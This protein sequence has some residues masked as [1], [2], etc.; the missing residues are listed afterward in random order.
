MGPQSDPAAWSRLLGTAIGFEFHKLAD[1]PRITSGPLGDSA[2]GPTSWLR[3]K[4]F[5]G[6][7]LDEALPV[8]Q[9]LVWKGLLVAARP[10]FSASTPT[11]AEL[12]YWEL[13]RVLSAAQLS[14]S[15]AVSLSPIKLGMAE[16][17][18]G[19]R[20]AIRELVAE[21]ARARIEVVLEP[22]PDGAPIPNVQGLLDEYPQLSLTVQAS[23]A[24]AEDDC[25]RFAGHRV[26]I[27]KGLP[28]PATNGWRTRRDIDLAYL[29]CT[30]ILMAGCGY[31]TIATDDLRMIRIV[32]AVATQAGRSDSDF[33]FELRLGTHADEQRRLADVGMKARVLVPYGDD[34]SSYRRRF[35]TP[36]LWGAR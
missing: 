31:P 2:Q 29:R 16:D 11:K 19:A 8:F 20:S 4:F 27:V 12:G 24:D 33:E 25:R 5:G 1:R 15:V 7:D 36:R 6:D 22:G 3:S 34:W 17:P 9:D 28:Q 35:L 14:D 13:L 10:M 21:A 30:R 32:G 23:L 18:D 26:R